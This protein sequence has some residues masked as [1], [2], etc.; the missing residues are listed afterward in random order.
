MKNFQ[1]LQLAFTR[2]LRSPQKTAL[3]EHLEDR[4]VGVYR[5]LVYNNIAG[6]ISGA[7]PVL[8]SLLDEKDWAAMVRDFLEVHQSQSPYFLDISQEFLTYLTHEREPQAKDPPF[9][10]E[11]AHYEWVELALDVADEELPPAFGV[12]LSVLDHHPRVSPLAWPLAYAFPVH[13]IGPGFQPRQAESPV[14]LLAY[15]NRKDEV[16]FMEINGLTFTLMHIFSEDPQLTG[17]AAL[18]C[19]GQRVNHANPE[20][21]LQ[22]GKML[23]EKL[24]EADIFLG[25]DCKRS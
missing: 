9:L 20:H 17:C 19:L 13:K 25:V 18:A 1:H 23:L 8:K 15:R 21:L 10:L 22:E 12:G 2:H 24:L 3:P 16:R 5:D 4:R 14:C 6:F 7:F 11:L